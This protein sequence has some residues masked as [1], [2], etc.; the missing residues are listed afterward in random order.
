MAR[1]RA[2][3]YARGM[4]TFFALFTLL[5]LVACHQEGPMEKAGHKADQAVDKAGQNLEKAGDKV[6]DAAK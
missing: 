6:R 1:C 2:S 3:P 4:K 5:A